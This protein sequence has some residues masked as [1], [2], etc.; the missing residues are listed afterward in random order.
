[1]TR[2]ELEAL[3]RDSGDWI[4]LRMNG[5]PMS[6]RQRLLGHHRG[7]KGWV[8]GH[9][10]PDNI[11][12]FNSELVLEYLD[13]LPTESLSWDDDVSAE[14]ATKELLDNYCPYL[15]RDET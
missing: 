11:V 13:N 9:K 2:A 3:A 12:R 5:D 15:I 8:V 14:A 10:S 7:P 4:F 6:S 1:M